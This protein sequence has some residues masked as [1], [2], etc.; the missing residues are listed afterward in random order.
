M[1]KSFSRN[2]RDIFPLVD[3][4]RIRF[5]SVVSTFVHFSR[6]MP[7]HFHGQCGTSQATRRRTGAILSSVLRIALTTLAAATAAAGFVGCGRSGGD[8]GATTTPV[9]GK[10]TASAPQPSADTDRAAAASGLP[11]GYSVLFDH[12]GAKASDVSYS[13]REPGKWEVKTGPAHILYSPGDTA[14]NKYTVSA[15]FEQLEAPAH[16]EAFGVFIGGSHLDSPTVKYTYFIVRG[17]GEYMIKVRDGSS[18][19]TITD[20]TANPVIPKQD[21]SGKA[22]YGLRIDVKDG[23]ASVSVNGAPLT[24]IS[25][26]QA[27]LNGVTGVRINHNLHL[28]VTPASLIR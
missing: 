3:A 7:T 21:A 8:A 25:G 14:A 10:I 24:T 15:T 4:R 17:D 22:L 20:W 18:T 6:Q 28:I 2:S 1:R 26:K 16:P 9:A 13:E 5:S 19:R 11:T 12:P 23:A 27:P